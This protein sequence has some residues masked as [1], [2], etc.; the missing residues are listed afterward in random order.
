MILNEDQLRDRYDR[1]Q[2][3][4]PSEEEQSQARGI[5]RQIEAEKQRKLNAWDEVME[6]V[7]GMR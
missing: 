5:L 7:F 6:R 1:I 2:N 4:P 3:R